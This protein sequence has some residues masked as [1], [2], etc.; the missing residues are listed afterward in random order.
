MLFACSAGGGIA[1]CSG[2]EEDR[3]PAASDDSGVDAPSR[4]DAASD[5]DG[6][7][8]SP[9][10]FVP[11]P[12][13]DASTM[14]ALCGAANGSDLAA[15]WAGPWGCSTHVVRTRFRGPRRAA[16]SIANPTTPS[17]RLMTA[18]ENNI[19][20]ATSD[21]E[22]AAIDLTSGEAITRRPAEHGAG[23]CLLSPGR[24]A[25]L[26]Q[27]GKDF[28]A[29]V[30]FFSGNGVATGSTVAMPT[31]AT[32]PDV[33]PGGEIYVAGD[34]DPA[35]PLALLPDG[36]T[37]KVQSL[38]SCGMPT[39]SRAGDVLYVP[40]VIAPK[41]NV[42]AAIDA[43]TGA[44]LW[45]VAATVTTT[46]MLAPDDRI[47]VG[48]E[49]DGSAA[50]QGYAP[51]GGKVLDVTLPTPIFVTDGGAFRG[52][53]NGLA[54]GASPD[55]DA[56]TYAVLAGTLELTA[57][58]PDGTIAW[59]HGFDGGVGMDVVDEEGWIFGIGAALRP[60]GTVGWT[61]VLPPDLDPTTATSLVIGG[62]G[63]LYVTS[64]KGL[65]RFAQ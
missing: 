54:L 23:W 33:G 42:L 30:V 62:D 7:A 61:A 5:G 3:P 22:M 15:P 13:A 26:D 48:A 36:G 49:L 10:V 53:I 6:D 27:C 1:A 64:N 41:T 43:V 63:A 56:S 35:S 11:G 57:V 4:L 2:C 60:D 25:C 55:G 29:E 12:A 34:N 46:T 18:S 38:G 51:D 50:L 58:R 39:P 28:H 40:C 37:R 47:Y 24:G 16:L 17:V 59:T 32:G 21:G 65:L 8:G 20:L 14:I 9:Y 45:H 52:V 31:C 44:E 19:A